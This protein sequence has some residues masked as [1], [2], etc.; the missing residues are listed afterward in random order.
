MRDFMIWTVWLVIVGP[1]VLMLLVF[2]F[3]G[4]MSGLA[5]LKGKK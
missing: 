1:T 2:A 4:I 5:A 3:I